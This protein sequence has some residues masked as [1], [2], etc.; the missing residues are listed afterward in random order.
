MGPG[1]LILLGSNT[2]TGSTT[3]SGGTLQVGNGGSGEFLASPS[4]SLTNSASL[5][6]S[7]SDSLTYSGLISG[8]GSLTQLGPGVLTLLGSN[9][10]SGG[11][12]ISAGTL[13]V[14]NGGSSASIG[15]TGNVLDNGSLVFNHGDA[16]TFSPLIGGSGSLTQTGAGILT[17]LGSNTYGGGTT[18][19]AGTLQLGNGGTTGSLAGSIA[20]GTAGTLVLDRS[21]NVTMNNTLTGP[22]G[23]LKTG[24]DT[25]TLTGNLTGYAGSISV[26][27][28]QLVLTAPAKPATTATYTANSGAT[29]TFQNA[30]F[31]MNFG[32]ITSASGG[33]VQYSNATVSNAYLSGS[34]LGASAGVQVLSASTTNS[35]NDVTVNN[36][37]VVQQNGP[38]TFTNVTN[39][40]LISGS[41]G[42]TWAGGQNDGSGVLVLSGTNNVSNWA[43][44]GTITIP[45]GGLLDNRDSNLTSWGGGVIAVNSGGTLNADSAAQ[46]AWLILQGSLVVNNGTILGTTNVGYGATVSGSGTYGPLN[47]S[48]L[49]SPGGIAGTIAV[50]PGSSPQSPSVVINNGTIA[51]NGVF[52]APTTI[53]TTAIVTSSAP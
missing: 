7:Q 17:L 30:A 46:G 6:F 52:A 1:A 29:L 25:V 21:D 38:A 22:G 15:G 42:L 23:L 27:Q 19:S 53:A 36:G 26:S 9:T 3:V 4:V 31:P 51:G 44:A 41:G 48:N 14:G 2:Y 11:T 39:R 47:V 8:S 28:G 32:S 24:G 37:A 50:A 34:S 35:F 45:N 5:V 12:T 18:I 16:V 33:T 43:N 13:Q 10:Y 40:G 20:V 49:S